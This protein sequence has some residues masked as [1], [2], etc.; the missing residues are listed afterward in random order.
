MELIPSRTV[1]AII[2]TV[3][4]SPMPNSRMATGIQARPGSSRSIFGVASVT[5]ASRPR[6]MPSTPAMATPASQRLRLLPTWCEKEWSRKG[7]PPN[8]HTT[9][10]AKKSTLIG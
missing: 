2:N 8:Q 9:N 10:P 1:M 7:V 6:A 5:P 4:T 3:A